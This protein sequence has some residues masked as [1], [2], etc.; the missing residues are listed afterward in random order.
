MGNICFWC[1]S[2]CSILSN[3]RQWMNCNLKKK[4]AIV[5]VYF[6]SCWEIEDNWKVFLSC[7][8]SKEIF[9]K[10]V[11]KF[12]PIFG[13]IYP[14]CLLQCIYVF[15]TITDDKNENQTS[16]FKCLNI[17]NLNLYYFFCVF[18]CHDSL[19]S[20]ITWSSERIALNSCS[21]LVLASIKQILISFNMVAMEI[22]FFWLVSNFKKYFLKWTILWNLH[23]AKTKLY[24]LLIRWRVLCKNIFQ[25]V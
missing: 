13:V 6:C 19:V 11:G 2:F 23:M 20:K 1:Q 10:N 16:F 18:V 25:T 15:S 12:S 8:Y 9:I 3:I 4:T 22:H 17:V 5:T 24:F 14:F 21:I 7:G